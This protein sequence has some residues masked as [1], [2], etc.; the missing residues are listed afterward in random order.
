MELDEIDAQLVE[1]LRLNGRSSNREVGR[2]LGISEGTVRQRLKKL[3]EGK[4]IKL[5]VVVD[6]RVYGA[7]AAAFVRIRAEP[8]HVQHLVQW[9]GA[10]ELCSFAG[11][12]LGRFDIIAL[13]GAPKREGLV[14]F[15]D[16]ELAAREGI[17]FLDVREPIGY[18]KHRFDL[19]HIP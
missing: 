14:N 2:I 10:S 11:I 6:A 16:Q 1:Q 12:T 5:G 13:L 19:I 9:I 18:A 15:I 3:E 7:P 8:K 4:L 17:V